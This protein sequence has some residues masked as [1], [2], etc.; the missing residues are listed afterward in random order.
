MHTQTAEPEL[1][2][3]PASFDID[4]YPE[5]MNEIR[6]GL[7]PAPDGSS[8]LVAVTRHRKGEHPF[9]PAKFHFCCSVVPYDSDVKK[10]LERKNVV[11]RSPKD[12]AE[13]HSLVRSLV[14]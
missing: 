8:V 11:Y 9:T 13:L 2:S 7:V 10:A 3:L 6:C 12:E 4:L 14:K 1:K 5:S